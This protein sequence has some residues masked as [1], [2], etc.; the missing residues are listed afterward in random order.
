M[1]LRHSSILRRLSGPLLGLLLGAVAHA[2]ET[3]GGSGY[4][5]R[6][7]PADRQPSGSDA[8]TDEQLKERQQREAFGGFAAEGQAAKTYTLES[9]STFI[10]IGDHYTIVPKGAVLHAPE[11]LQSALVPAA[12][13]TFMPWP[14]F[15]KTYRSSVSRFD[16][17]LD[18]ASGKDPLDADKLGTASK[19]A[20]LVVAMFQG[21]AISVAKAPDNTASNNATPNPR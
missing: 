20:T 19:S 16:V 12:Q 13:G 7:L 2:E 15:L 21:G 17:T 9:M 10:R 1:H 18:Q 11:R 4:G 5:I 6:F 3:A 8:V 14:E